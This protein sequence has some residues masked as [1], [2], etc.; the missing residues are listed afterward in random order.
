MFIE[1]TI[2]RRMHHRVRY[3]EFGGYTDI[4]RSSRHKSDFQLEAIQSTGI[5]EKTV[6]HR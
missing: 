3:V 4:L 1:P 5:L 2:I 6:S